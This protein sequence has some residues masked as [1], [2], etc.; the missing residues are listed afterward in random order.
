MLFGQ[1]RIATATTA[2][3]LALFDCFVVALVNVT[4]RRD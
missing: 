4:Q 3:I 1:G 2:D